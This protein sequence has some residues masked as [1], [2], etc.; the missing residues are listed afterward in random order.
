MKYLIDIFV[1][2]T[3]IGMVFYIYNIFVLR[4]MI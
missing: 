2:L 1:T 4:G 3:A